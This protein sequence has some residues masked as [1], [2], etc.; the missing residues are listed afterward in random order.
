MRRI[1]RIVTTCLL[2][3]FSSRL[4]SPM[5]DQRIQTSLEGLTNFFEETDAAACGQNGKWVPDAADGYNYG[6]GDFA[7]PTRWKWQDRAANCHIEALTRE[8][9]CKVMGDDGLQLKRI[10]FVGDSLT[11]QMV[12]SMWRL[13]GNKDAPSPKGKRAY[14]SRTITCDIIGINEE[15]HAPFTIEIAYTRN[16]HLSDGLN[17][18]TTPDC[19]PSY[20]KDACIPWV[21]HYNTDPARTLLIANMGSHIGQ[22]DQYK[23][24]LDQFVETIQSLSRPS[25]MI[26]FRTTVPGHENCKDHTSPLNSTLDFHTPTLYNWKNF[27]EYNRYTKQKWSNLTKE[28]GEVDYD[29]SWSILDVYPMTILRPDGHRLPNVDC[30]H[31]LLPGPVD[32]WNHLLYRNLLD[33]STNY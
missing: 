33:L 21:D 18:S 16:D 4:L 30:M 9:F 15:W 7:P 27:E 17:G 29:H 13:L 26:V 24:K 6:D 32:W 10:F 23:Y 19:T 25:D 2:W 31:Y 5:L 12:E 28:H 1:F 22:H 8:G 14:F 11:Y 20:S 3:T